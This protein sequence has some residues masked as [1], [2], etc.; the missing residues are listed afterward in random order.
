[1]FISP[2]IPVPVA[3]DSLICTLS[4]LTAVSPALPDP[5][6][7]ALTSEEEDEGDAEG[8]IFNSSL[9]AV[10]AAAAAAVVVA[11]VAGTM[12]SCVWRRRASLEGVTATAPDKAA[13]SSCVWTCDDAKTGGVTTAEVET[14]C[15]DCGRD[16]SSKGSAEPVALHHRMIVVRYMMHLS[17]RVK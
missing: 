2:P 3:S 8:A 11:A 14:D 9:T 7:N 12:G 1:V 4:V 10:I 16:A 13:A 15:C 5:E 17:V 6:Y